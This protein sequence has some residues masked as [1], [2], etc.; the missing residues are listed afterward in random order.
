MSTYAD[1]WN[2][3]R[4][5]VRLTTMRAPNDFIPVRHGGYPTE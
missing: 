1:L 4:E 3:A 5:H 2:D